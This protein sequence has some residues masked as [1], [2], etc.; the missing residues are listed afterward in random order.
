[1]NSVQ[2]IQFIINVV[3]GL[4]AVGALIYT[5]LNL[6]SQKRQIHLQVFSELLKQIAS[7]EARNDRR[8]VYGIGIIEGQEDKNIETIKSLIKA[9]RNQ[10]EGDE[11]KKGIAVERTIAT[12]DRVGFFLLSDAKKPKTKPPLWLWEIVNDMWKKLGDWVKFREDP[13]SGDY[14]HKG[15]GY[16]FRRLAESPYNENYWAK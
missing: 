5:A 16:Y 9:V 14:Y 6:K 4:A 2:L 8:L 11:K 10:I 7:D 3:I 13:K 12:L 1:M 15:H